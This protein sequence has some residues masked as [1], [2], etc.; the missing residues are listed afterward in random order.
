MMA[1]VDG[2]RSNAFGSTSR[3]CVALSLFCVL[4]GCGGGGSGG[5][6]TTTNANALANG[7]WSGTF[8]ETGGIASDAS[9]FLYNGQIIAFVFPDLILDGTYDVINGNDFSS[10]VS[11]YRIYSAPWTFADISGTVTEQG[12]ISASFNVLS[13]SGTISLLYDLLYNRTSSLSLVEG[14]WNYTNGAYSIT[15]TVDSAGAF[16][17]RDSEGCVVPGNISLLDTAHNIYD[18]KTS[19][20]NCGRWDGYYTGFSALMDDVTTNDTLQ[21]MVTNREFI[22]SQPVIYF[23]NH[24]AITYRFTRL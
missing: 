20:S 8:S 6:E 24:P 13:T 21:V 3:I 1:I 7:L 18:M 22:R 16:V 2:I 14:S 9:A 23:S 12:S 17:A 11:V 19:T 10:R 4:A 15:I 5:G